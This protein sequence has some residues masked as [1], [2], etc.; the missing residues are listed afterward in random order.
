MS[1]F[2]AVLHTGPPFL[3]SVLGVPGFLSDVSALISA[4]SVLVEDSLVMHALGLEGLGGII[5]VNA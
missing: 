2:A 1:T 4:V 5:Q 3:L